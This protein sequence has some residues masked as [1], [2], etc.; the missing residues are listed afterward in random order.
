MSS[1]NKGKHC[2]RMGRKMAEISN[3]LPIQYIQHVEISVASQRKHF[4]HCI[5]SR[6]LADCG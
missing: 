5:G 1:E 2:E 4:E 6:L 3:K